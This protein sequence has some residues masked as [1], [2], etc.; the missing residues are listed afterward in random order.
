MKKTYVK[1]NVK[2]LGLL[3]VVTQFSCG[4]NIGT[5]DHNVPADI[6]GTFDTPQDRHAAAYGELR[7]GLQR[8]SWAHGSSFAPGVLPLTNPRSA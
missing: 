6:S 8:S 3:R 4:P 7:A 1:P 5:V 2:G